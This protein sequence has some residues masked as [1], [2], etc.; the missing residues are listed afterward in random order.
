ML[1][2]SFKKKLG[3]FLP[4]SG[5]ATISVFGGSEWKPEFDDKPLNSEQIDRIAEAVPSAPIVEP[6][7]AR[8]VLLYSATNGFRHGSI[9][10]GIH[11]FEMMAK[12]TGAYEIVTSDAPV[13]FEKE[14]LQHFDAVI[15]FNSTGNFFLPTTRKGFSIRDQFDDVEW[16]HLEARDK[17]LISNLVNYVRSGGGF[18]GIHAATDA[19][20]GNWDYR[21][22]I[23]GTFMGH[24]WTADQNVTI[25]V[26]DTQH[27][28]TSPVFGD[29]ELFSIKEEIYQFNN[30]YSRERQ[31]VLLSL[32]PEQSDKPKKEPRREDNDYAI[33]W[34]KDEGQGRVFYSAIG[35]NFENFWSADILNHYL[36]GIQFATG[37]LEVDTTPSKLPP[38]LQ[39]AIALRACECNQH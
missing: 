38:S 8:K 20:Y 4:L 23:G 39:T 29:E 32:V 5:I 27:Q 9:P 10:V 7:K 35:H 1:G 33:A 2:R 21:N 3:A 26:E 12:S 14:N 16:A 13:N 22:M 24:P 11:A 30:P 17:R 28:L 15:V 25:K 18:V 37:D 31:R 6:Q 19:Y 34:V 36:A